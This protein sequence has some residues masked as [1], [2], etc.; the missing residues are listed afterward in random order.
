MGNLASILDSEGHYAEAEKLYRETLVL[1]RRVLG[2]ENPYT[3]ISTYNL[4]A[5]AAHQG[6]DAE[7]ISLLRESVDHGLPPPYALAIEKDTDLKSL[8]GDPRFVAL[9]AHVKERAAASQKPN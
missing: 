3:A 5:A 1:Q 7:A 8:Y 4:G 6:R 9:V 2:P